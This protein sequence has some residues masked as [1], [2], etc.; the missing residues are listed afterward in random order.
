M[1]FRVRVRISGRVKV[2]IKFRASKCFGLSVKFKA[3]QILESGLGLGQ[4]TMEFYPQ[5]GLVLVSG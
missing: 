2:R 4:G 1:F 5:L 3:H